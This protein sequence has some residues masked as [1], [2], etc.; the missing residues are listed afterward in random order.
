MDLVHSKTRNSIRKAQRSGVIVRH[1][2][3]T[4]AL[5]T[6]ARIH[7]EQI[8]AIGGLSKSIE[9]FLTVRD[10]FVYDRDY[11]VYLAEKDGVTI[12]ALLVFFSHRTAEFH[13][14]ATLDGFRIYQPM[15]LLVYEA[16]QEAARRGCR[17]WNWG[18]TWLTQRGVY[19]FKRRWGTQDLPYCYFTRVLNEKIRSCTKEQLLEEYPYFYVVP[20]ERLRQ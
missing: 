3:S 17:Y 19:F 9:V 18:G 20:F 12:A 14:P 11:R 5:K 4:E 13:T 6:L 7:R 2:E 8:A 10:V 15:S 16:M 1:F